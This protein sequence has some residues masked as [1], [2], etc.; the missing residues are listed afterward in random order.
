MIAQW[1]LAHRAFLHGRSIHNIQIEH[2]WRDM[3]KDSLEAFRQ[4]FIYLEEIH[5]LDMENS[6]HQVCL[7]LVFHNRIQ[8]SLDRT[9][10]AWNHHKLH[11]AAINHRYWTGDPGDDLKTAS[12]LAYS[13]YGHTLMPP[14]AEMGDDSEEQGESGLEEERAAGVSMN[15]DDELS[16]AQTLLDGFDADADDGNWG[17]DVYCEAVLLLVS[18]LEAQ[19]QE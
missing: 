13:F 17:I 12:D 19:N 2:L 4:V 15:G 14:A 6:I 11:E 10:D 1:G 18:R 3:Q 16:E 5:L 9:C 8:K 7:Y